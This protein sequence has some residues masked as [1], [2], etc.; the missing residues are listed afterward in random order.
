MH[1]Y[2]Q[3]CAKPSA[4]PLISVQI[5]S[6]RLSVVAPQASPSSLAKTFLLWRRDGNR[7]IPLPPTVQFDFWSP[8][9]SAAISFDN[10]PANIMLKTSPMVSSA[11]ST[12]STNSPNTLRRGHISTARSSISHDTPLATRQA[13]SAPSQSI[14]PSSLSRRPQASLNNDSVTSQSQQP[15]NAPGPSAPPQSATS[16]LSATGA[17]ESGL[18]PTTSNT[19]SASSSSGSSIL[20]SS[21][22]DQNSQRPTASNK[23]RGSGA[24]LA[25]ELSGNQQD[26]SN[27]SS[28]KKSKPEEPPP[29][30]LPLRYELCP[31]EDMVECIA[32]MLTDLINTNDAIGTSSGGLTRF[33]S[34]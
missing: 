17:S 5:S 14:S 25:S 26:G 13:S 4:I 18:Y 30:V 7:R 6:T 16:E 11:A 27:S 23:R 29:K 2:C 31:I 3:H 28:S 10:A 22:S 12:T 8:S 33:H 19:T 15:I 21:I 34:R 32:N 24:K 1:A 9:H 20:S